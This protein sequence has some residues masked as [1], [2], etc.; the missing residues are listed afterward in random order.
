MSQAAAAVGTFM[1]YSAALRKETEFEGEGNGRRDWLRSHRTS[2]R[3]MRAVPYLVRAVHRPAC[4]I[5]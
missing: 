5:I 2:I 1:V 3:D 4:K